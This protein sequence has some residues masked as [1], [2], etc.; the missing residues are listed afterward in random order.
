MCL[1]GHG[2]YFNGTAWL[3]VL[4]F[5]N[6]TVGSLD[7]IAIKYDKTKA[8]DKA[9]EQ[10]LS[11]NVYANPID[12]TMCIWLGMGIFIVVFSRQI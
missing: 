9:G 3:A 7:S 11:K 2:H 5:H 8:A 6:F 12:W 1:L 4:G 10:L